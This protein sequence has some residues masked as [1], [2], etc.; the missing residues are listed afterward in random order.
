MGYRD[1]KAPGVSVI[2]ERQPGVE[3]AQLTQFFPVF[4]GTGMT[5]SSRILA[6]PGMVADTSAFPLV[7]FT[8]NVLGLLNSQLFLETSLALTSLTIDKQIGGTG[9][10]TV[11]LVLT[12]DYTITTPIS[13]IGSD[14]QVTF[15][16]SIIK[17]GILDTDLA[18][19]FTITATNT[20]DDFDLRLLQSSDVYY[21]LDIVGPYS[22]TEGSATFTNDIA[23]AAEIAFRMKVPSF[24]YLEVP[25]AY[26]VKATSSAIIAALEKIYY[27]T[28]AYRIIPLT[29]DAGVTTAVQAL[30]S[31]ISN[32]LDKR[33]TVGFVTYPTA[34]I[35]S[36]ADIDELVTKVGG[37]SVSLNTTRI[38]N[39]FGCSSVDMIL[40]NAVVN[41]PACFLTAAVAALD[42]ALGM[43]EPL[44]LREINVFSRMYGPRFRPLDWN[45]LADKRV[46][47]V[48]QNDASAPLVIRHQLTTSQSTDAQDQEYSLV[49]N[50]DAV[51]ILLRERLKPYSGKY[52]IIDGY[53][54]KLDAALTSAI[55]EA[56]DLG[57]ARDIVVLS[58]WQARKIPDP[59]G[60]QVENR[61]LVT[62]LKMTPAYPA[63]NLDLYL[64]V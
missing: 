43:A 56:K 24:Y 44:S 11:S 20:V 8:F 46:F 1:Y 26:G 39:V 13:A 51:S 47:I 30:V 37:L 57:L 45:K 10:T 25:R 28:N 4:V 34:D 9:P 35:T 53:M 2:V 50:I 14:G 19:E 61:N 63:N 42:S 12:T 62:R 49:K 29:D 31:S 48:Y 32:P 58:P 6:F 7:T 64:L 18:Y 40:N 36:M 27:K 38:N 59:N 54:E 60:T 17:T 41:L 5:S 3:T 16:V 22:L 52:N 21:A 23:V 15:T 55:H 33:E